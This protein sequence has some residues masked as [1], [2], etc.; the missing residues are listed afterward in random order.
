M[1]SNVPNFPGHVTLSHWSNGDPKWSAGPPATDAILT[2]EYLK[3]YFNSSDA[4]R[5]ADWR[6]RCQEVTAVNATCAIPEV[7]AAPNG[8][9]SA[10]T[11]FFSQQPNMAA[12]QIVSGSKK[13]D[14]TAL[15][16]SWVLYGVV[17]LLYL[18]V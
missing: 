15:T 2:I 17:Y 4:G 6:K 16:G 5:Q 13:S 7:M 12:N 10:K 11:F 1:T 3:G 9:D 14:A 18:L 8:N